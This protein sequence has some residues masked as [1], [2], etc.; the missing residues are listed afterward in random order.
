[1]V[2]I[3]CYIMQ[4]GV[5][6]NNFNTTMLEVARRCIP[7]TSSASASSAPSPTGEGNRKALFRQQILNETVDG[8]MGEISLLL[9]EKGDRVSG[10]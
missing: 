4:S 5:H 3:K 1:M 9:R 2:R 8:R 7:T 10:G 6:G